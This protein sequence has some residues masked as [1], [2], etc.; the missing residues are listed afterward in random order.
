[1]FRRKML[2][3]LADLVAEG[4]HRGV[5]P[6][7]LAGLSEDADALADAVDNRSGLTRGVH[8]LN[9][10]EGAGFAENPIVGRNGAAASASS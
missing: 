10:N 8:A 2:N 1:M 3:S 7:K 4:E 6:I 9:G 5:G